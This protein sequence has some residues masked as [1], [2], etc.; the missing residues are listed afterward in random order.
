MGV[1]LILDLVSSL[2]QLMETFLKETEMSLLEPALEA[3]VWEAEA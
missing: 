3:G 2:S 1:E